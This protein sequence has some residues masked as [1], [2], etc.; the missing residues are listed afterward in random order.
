MYYGA[1]LLT[2]INPSFCSWVLLFLNYYDLKTIVEP[3]RGVLRRTAKFV[4]FST[5]LE[6][7]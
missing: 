5:R 6:G 4:K 1:S 3:Y 2:S 7:L